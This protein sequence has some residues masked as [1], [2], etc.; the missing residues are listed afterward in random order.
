MQMLLY[1]FPLQL[2]NETL[3]LDPRPEYVRAKVASK[4]GKL[5]AEVTDNQVCCMFFF[6]IHILF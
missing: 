2:L 6:F 5:Y 4:D 3:E 1:F